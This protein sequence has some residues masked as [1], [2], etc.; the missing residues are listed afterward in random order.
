[1]LKNGTDKND[2]NGTIDFLRAVFC[3]IILLFHISL[4]LYGKEWGPEEWKGLYARWHRY[5]VEIRVGE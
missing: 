1:M 4:D 3:I 5:D 2:R